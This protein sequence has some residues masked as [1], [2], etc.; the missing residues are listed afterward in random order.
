MPRVKQMLKNTEVEIAKA[1]RTCKFTKESITKGTP[2][3]VVYDGRRDR[4][5]YSVDIALEMIKSARARLDE[6]EH[7]LNNHLLS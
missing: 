3:L 2:C 7:E 5:C 6:L 1:R 4:S